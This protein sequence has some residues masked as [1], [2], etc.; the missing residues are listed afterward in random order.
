MLIVSAIEQLKKSK[1]RSDEHAILEYFQKKGNSINQQ[2]LP[3][4]IASLS[5]NGIIIKKPSSDKNS[6]S[7]KP[8][9]ATEKSTA[10]PTPLENPSTPA[11]SFPNE[12][13]V[14]S[15]SHDD[16]RIEQI[17]KL[18]AEVT[19]QKSF[20]AEQLSVIKKSVEDFRLEN[21]TL[22]NLKLIETFKEEIR[23]LR[24]E[25]IT[26]TCIIKSLNENQATDYV[27][28][29]T[30]RKV[31]QRDTAIQTEVITKSWLQEEIPPQ[32]TSSANDRKSGNNPPLK[33]NKEK[34]RKKLCWKLNS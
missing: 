34:V 22:N 23:Y 27:K 6:F 20:I 15:E 4:S 33:L 19:A 8:I 29:I 28:T 25:N 16:Y 26:K 12:S 32:N 9:I 18:S 30:T 13:R 7:V 17:E 2:T 14:F 10:T 1:K 24:N 31:H 3:L 5:K 21:V 11:S